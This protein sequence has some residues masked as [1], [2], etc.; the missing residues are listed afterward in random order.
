MFA[1]LKFFVTLITTFLCSFS[2]NAACTLEYNAQSSST[3][4][5]DALALLLKDAPTCPNHVLELR[6]LFTSHGLHINST[7]V[8]NEGFHHPVDGSF[9]FFEFFTGQIKLSEQMINIDLGDLSIG[10]FTTLYQ[11]N[12]LILD[13]L[14]SPQKLLVEAIAWDEK[15]GAYN[16]YELREN[17]KAT[18]WYYR[19]D[20]YDIYLD[21]QLLHRQKNAFGTRLRC[22]GCHSSGGLIMKELDSPH[23]DW[24]QKKRPLLFGN[25]TIDSSVTDI[26]KELQSAKLMA[27]AVN[28]GNHKLISHPQFNAHLHALSLQ[29]QLRPLFCPVELNLKSDNKPLLEKHAQIEIPVE[30]FVDHRLLPKRPPSSI[31]ISYSDYDN[32]MRQYHSQFPQTA[33]PDSDHAWLTPVKAISD[34]MMVDQLMKDGVIDEKFVYDVL[35]IDF[36]NPVLSQTR[37]GLLRYLPDSATENWRKIFMTHLQTASEPEAKELLGHMT[38]ARHDPKYHKKKVR[39]YLAG[40]KHE[41]KKGHQINNYYLL[42]LQRRAEISASAISQNPLGQIL[43]PGFR[44]IFPTTDIVPL[45]YSL[46]LDERCRA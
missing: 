28:Q 46:A 29:E 18:R 12:T 44:V 39:R 38:N 8:A 21:N 27:K 26:I 2:L 16:F 24:W 36:T 33:L 6:R 20:T 31:T 9:S 40:C 32:L 15:K 3:D 23:N 14:L 10:H 11:Q 1:R 34:V 35:M 7:M 43:E 5:H 30:F 25:Y 19:G 42:L 17:E 37:C 41:I 45:P 4:L 13:Q 22:S